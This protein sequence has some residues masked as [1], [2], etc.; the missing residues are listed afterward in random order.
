MKEQELTP[1]ARPT[2][3]LILVVDDF[4]DSRAMFA[5]FL[6]FSGY[7]V[8]Q[9]ANGR[10]AVDLAIEKQPDIIVMDLSLPVMDGWEAARTLRADPRTKHIRIIALTG[11]ALEGHL[12]R[13]REAGCDDILAKPC[14][15]ETLVE[16][17]KQ[18]LAAMR[19]PPA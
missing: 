1:S 2:P 3:P 6:I 9:A 7:R 16:R 12:Q 8:E 13:A 15:P 4:E 10:E 11:H 17:L 19:A 18:H 14:L 5:E